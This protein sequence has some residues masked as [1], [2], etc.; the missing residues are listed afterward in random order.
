MESTRGNCR[1]RKV[2]QVLIIFVYFR[3]WLKHVNLKKKKRLEK[4]SAAYIL[5][6]LKSFRIV[7]LRI[8]IVSFIRSEKDSKRR[9]IGE[10]IY[11]DLET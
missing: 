10:H 11:K 7:V 1:T 9:A 6:L 3:A 2:C 8:D 5:S 4:D